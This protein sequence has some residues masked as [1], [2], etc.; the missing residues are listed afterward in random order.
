MNE[1]DRAREDRIRDFEEHDLEHAE[2]FVQ[3]HAD[4]AEKIYSQA[5]SS[6]W[7]GNSGVVLATLSSIEAPW[8]DGTFPRWLL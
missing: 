2:A 8:K 1:G 3:R 4:L 6:L 7:H 5:I